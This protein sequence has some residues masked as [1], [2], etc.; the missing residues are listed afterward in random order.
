MNRLIDKMMIHSELARAAKLRGLTD[1]LMINEKSSRNRFSTDEISSV[2]L[3]ILR[4]SN[5][6]CAKAMSSMG[7]NA[8]IDSGTS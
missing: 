6:K 3:L 2:L 8:M 7:L 5:S 4:L 1:K